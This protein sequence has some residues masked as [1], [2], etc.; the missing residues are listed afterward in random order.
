MGAAAALLA[1][2][3]PARITVRALAARSGVSV[4]TIYQF[5]ADVEA[6]RAAVSERTYADFRAALAA[7]LTREAALA[8]PG[9][10]FRT[11]VDVIGELQKRHPQVGCLVRVDHADEFRAA[12]AEELRQLIAAHI[13]SA[14]GDAFPRMARK[15]RE[16]RLEV[17]QSVL[18][19]ALRT[20]PTAP[21]SARAAH[22]IQAKEAVSLYADASF[23]R[24]GR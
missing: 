10:F 14:F 15:E 23:P 4:G 1:G 18:L 22:L 13:R 12:Y 19:G 9:G 6:V 24:T 8:S 2:E 17:A 3:A 16:L 11:L 20:M 5:F 7:H 21:L